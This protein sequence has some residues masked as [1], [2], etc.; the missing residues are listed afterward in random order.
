M[1]CRRR[2]LY[3]RRR[4]L[5]ELGCRR[6]RN[7]RRRLCVLA[8]AADKGDVHVLLLHRRRWQDRRRTCRAERGAG[9]SP[10]PSVWPAAA[11]GRVGLP[12]A[13]VWPAA[14]LRVGGGGGQGRR[15]R[16]SAPPP[17]FAGPAADLSGGDGRW[18]VAAAVG[19]AGGG[20][21]ARRVA[22]V[23]GMAGG[24]SACWRGRQAGETCTCIC[25]AAGVGK[26]G[27][28]PVGRRGALVR[29]RRRRYGRRRLRVLPGT[30]GK[31]DVHELLPRRRRRQDRWRACLVGR[32]AGV[33]PPVLIWP[34]AARCIGGCW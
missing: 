28:G 10:P 5:G 25:F 27:G 4:R 33:S 22:A 14:A 9:V 29:L 26:T 15:A 19:V 12:P 1:V 34:A 8:G 3:G 24:G 13:S 30:A 23:F 32:G 7:G 18:C 2:R 11:I 6:L 17:A 31:G 20:T 21:W 16:S